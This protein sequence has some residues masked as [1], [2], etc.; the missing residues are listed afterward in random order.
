MACVSGACAGGRGASHGGAPG[1]GMSPALCKG[2]LHA[3]TCA[4]VF[5][6]RHT[7]L[8]RKGPSSCSSW[9]TL[10]VSNHLLQEEKARKKC[11][12]LLGTQHSG[13]GCTRGALGAGGSRSSRCIH[14]PSFQP[15]GKINTASKTPVQ[16]HFTCFCKSRL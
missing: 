2:H 9:K 4:G 10:G 3:H 1:R 7:H 8:C 15:A 16:H 14:L 5:V 11:L 12:I 13:P 6:S